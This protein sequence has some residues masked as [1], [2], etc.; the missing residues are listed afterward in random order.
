MDNLKPLDALNLIGDIAKN[1]DTGSRDGTSLLLLVEHMKK[2]EIFSVQ[3]SYRLEKIFEG[4]YC[5]SDSA[6]FLLIASLLSLI[7][8]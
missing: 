2:M 4:C 3:R 7:L 1:G 8:L 6:K 5:Y